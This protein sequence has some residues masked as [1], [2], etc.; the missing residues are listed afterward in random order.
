MVASC[1]Q[2]KPHRSP[3]KVNFS[4]VIGIYLMSFFYDH[5]KS[6]FEIWMAQM[7]VSFYLMIFNQTLIRRFLKFLKSI[8]ASEMQKQY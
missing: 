7:K 2:D 4:C 6:M 1:G 5:P 8:S 3:K